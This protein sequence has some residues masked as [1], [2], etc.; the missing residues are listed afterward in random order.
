MKTFINLLQKKENKMKLFNFSQKGG[1]MKE[2]ALT[3]LFFI[4]FIQPAY[5][6][7]LDFNQHDTQVL[8]VEPDIS[9]LTA[10]SRQIN[11]TYDIPGIFVSET[12]HDSKKYSQFD[13]PACGHTTD[14]GKPR[15]P[16][17]GRYIAVPD[18]V[19]PQV[20]ITNKTA[21]DISSQFVIF[22]AQEPGM[23]SGDLP[24]PDFVADPDFYSLS[25]IDRYY[26]V[27]DPDKP[28]ILSGP[29][30]VRGLSLYILR[31]YPMIYNPEKNKLVVWSSLD[32]SIS[33]GNQHQEYLNTRLQSDSFNQI[34]KKL[35]L[36]YDVLDQKTLRKSAR[37]AYDSGNSLL[38]ITS[39]TF[40]DA[41]NTLRV[42]KIQKGIET[43]V[44]TTDEIGDSAD[45]IA[46]YIQQAYDSWNPPPT[47]ILF[48]GDAE[49]V[50]VHYKTV[51]PYHRN[52]TGTDLY[53]ATVDGDDYFPDICIGRLSIDTE[54]Q[55]IK[56]I[57]DIIQYEKNPVTDINFYKNPTICAYF[58][59][60]G[61]GYASRR[62]AQT[63]EDI[64]IFLSEKAYTPNRIYYTPSSVSPLYWTVRYF[65]GGPA[66]GMGS[67][68][69]SYLLKSSGFNWLGNHE[70]ISQ[71]I[72]NGTFIVTHRDHGSVT[73]W[74][75][76][77]YT[78]DHV[79]NLKNINK[80]PVVFSIN[81]QTGWFDNETDEKTNNES[82]IAFSEAWERNPNGGAVGVVA[83]TRVSYS[84]HNDRLVWGWIDALW[85]DFISN[86]TPQ[87][88]PFDHPKF[89]MGAVLNYGKY[90]YATQYDESTVRQTEFE[91]FHYFGDPS[92]QIRTEMPEALT[93]SHALTLSEGATSLEIELNNNLNPLI[94]ITLNNEILAKM[95]YPG[96][97]TQISWSTPLT[98]N[99]E[100]ILTITG[101]NCSTYISTIPVKQTITSDYNI[102]SS[103]YR[104]NLALKEDGT[105][106]AWGDNRQGQLGDGT[107]VDKN[108][109]VMVK[110]LSNVKSIA[111]GGYHS[112]ALKNDGSIWAWGDNKYGQLGDGT[113]MDKREAVQIVDVDHVIAIAADFSHSMA[114]KS[115]GTVWAWGDNGKFQLGED[116]DLSRNVPGIVSHLDNVI[117]IDCGY[118]FSLALKNDGTVWAWGENCYGQLGDGKIIDRSIPGPVIAL[119]NVRQFSAGAY[120]IIALKH[121]GT[122]FTWGYNC[123]GQL[124]DQSTI[125]KKVPTHVAELNN[126]QFVAAGRYHSMAIQQNGDAFVWGQNK[127]GELGDGTD[128]DKHYPEKLQ[129]VNNLKAMTGGLYQTIFVNNDGY[130]W[131]CGFN[132]DGV[133]GD[134]N[135]VERNQNSMTTV[136]IN[137]VLAIDSGYGHNIA[138]KQDGT[139]WTWGNNSYGQ[140]GDETNMDRE[141]P[142]QVKNIESIKA[143]AAGY[144]HNLALK[145][146]GTVWTWGNNSY[147]QLGEGISD[148]NIARQ[149]AKIDNVKA[150]AGGRYHSLSLKHDGTVWAWGRNNYG[151]LGYD[152]VNESRIPGQVETLSDVKNIYAGDYHSIAI[153]NDGSVWAWGHNNNG[154]L[155]NAENTDSTIPVKVFGLSDIILASAGSDH[156]IA[157]K[158]DGTVWAWG[159][160]YYGQIGNDSYTDCNS[161]VQIETFVNAVAINDQSFAWDEMNNIYQWGKK[162][163]DYDI[164][165]YSYSRIKTPELFIG[166]SEISAFAGGYKFAIALTKDDNVSAWG[167][168]LDGQFG[169]GTRKWIPVEVLDSDGVARLTLFSKPIS[170]H[171]NVCWNDVPYNRMNLYLFGIYGID[172]ALGDEIGLFDGPNCIGVGKIDTILS[173]KN[174]LK[175]TLSMTD[176]DD[177]GFTPGNDIVIKFWNQQKEFVTV[178]PQF[179]ELSTGQVVNI[180]KYEANSDFGMRLTVNEFLTI[181][182]T[183]TSGGT[184]TPSGRISVESGINQKFTIQPDPGY[185]ILDILIDNN[186]SGPMEAYTFTKIVCDHTIS[187]IFEKESYSITPTITGLNGRIVPGTVQEVG[188][189][190]ELVF[191]IIPDKCFETGDI[192]IDGISIGPASAYTFSNVRANH[193]IV[194]EFQSEQLSQHFSTNSGW[195]YFAMTVSPK[196]KN[197]LDLFQSESLV[198]IVG[199]DKQNNGDATVQMI[200]GDWRNEIGDA[201][202]G[203][204]YKIQMKS[205]HD[206]PEIKGYP[207]QC[208]SDPFEI[209]LKKGFNFVGYFCAFAQDMSTF[210]APLMANNTL[211]KA[212]GE[213][214][215]VLN[216]FGEWENTISLAQSGK[217]Y[218]IKV[219]QDTV[220]PVNCSS[221]DKRRCSVI[222][223]TQQNNHQTDHFWPVWQNV[224]FNRMNFHVVQMDNVEPGDE[225][226]I[227]DISDQKICAGAAVIEN[228]IS[229]QNRLIVTT[230]QKEGANEGF[231]VGHPVIFKFFDKS[232]QTEKS[233]LAPTFLNISNGEP[234]TVYQFEAN[235]DYAV[236]LTVLQFQHVIHGM[237]F[238]AG[239]NH[240]RF[241]LNYDKKTT[242]AD[243]I[244][245][246]QE[247][248]RTGTQYGNLVLNNDFSGCGGFADDNSRQSKSNNSSETLTWN[249]NTDTHLLSFINK[250]VWLNCCGKH[251]IGVFYD[252][253]TNT[254]Q[255][256]EKD[257]PEGTE[258]DPLRCDCMCSFD[259]R[260]DISSDNQDKI[261]VQLMRHITDE[262]QMPALVWKGEIKLSEGSGEISFQAE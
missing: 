173:E 76:P 97:K 133:L 110:G 84:G 49:Y 112:F 261:K 65:G 135:L 170:N 160:N 39:P 147:G 86:Y 210:L 106:W 226:S 88:T 150:V 168:N 163:L 154:Q 30:I 235:E 213:N 254:Y 6:Y 219:N 242:I 260:A 143:I 47:Y 10:T 255:I 46:A 169:D 140:L 200:L 241:D 24:E 221:K 224:P 103:G 139:V 43:L 19:V 216:I 204:L 188:Y 252:G 151:Q 36:N 18:G 174:Y 184:I 144:R 121:D 177:C 90:Y 29:F 246:L 32:I 182:S 81:C 125:N 44:K 101:H 83:S 100:I 111:C 214:G 87:G 165:S 102:V 80:L 229:R 225:I 128:I 137:N 13:L 217:G 130:V 227:F 28:Y 27:L 91:M 153:K 181:T 198:K 26:P 34:F 253:P 7:W 23:D 107:T 22:P 51:H 234:T 245:G 203:Q 159:N 93:V 42:W 152:I 79:N 248:A 70:D 118:S 171:F 5:S 189:G 190:S 35:V 117:A 52:K 48:I 238:L 33:L 63:S 185:V 124:G 176:G 175:I 12:A 149:M 136:K 257:A 193:T 45:E 196:R 179:L 249:I 9:V 148:S 212:I 231:T 25:K 129:Y 15:L 244:Y 72:T 208:Q 233:I 16:M 2:K 206:Y 69:P 95:E 82:T 8:P 115:D 132:I 58:Q 68:I 85:S 199:R 41:A 218:E 20:T 180:S 201:Q 142:V 108:L 123:S 236:T 56:R 134:G 92:M 38:I 59:H 178:T 209:Q 71:A 155:G 109:P 120:H 73:G 64:A 223:K 11:V 207:C 126:I 156:N 145:E 116:I 1:L 21:A 37:T 60:A 14:T 187:A 232:E 164:G 194:V 146:D 240:L 205:A 57:N 122:V 251:D 262:S 256:I 17:I 31:I 237:Q 94:C 247:T 62:F 166:Q 167:F 141:E 89:E 186:S 183:T 119:D 96:Y 161:P 192:I 162:Y 114:L 55:A 4:M 230:S 127:Y 113:N 104:H 202:C 197:M 243:I 259:Y 220:L 78:V 172:Y 66:G 105:V 195:N 158:A 250:D 138:L 67:A 61:N 3:I 53:Y 40:I 54:A 77:Y 239:M 99:D 131:S 74:G 157:I 75:D 191:R 98:I 211:I 215:S 50:P 222:R 258:N 228:N